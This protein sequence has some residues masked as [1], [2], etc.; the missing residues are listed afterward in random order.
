MK[1]SIK[2]LLG[3]T[4][5][6]ADG[7]IGKVADFYFDDR[8][9]T[10]RYMVVK[11]GGWFFEK[12]VLISSEAF[13]KSESESKTFSVN[14]TQEKIKNSPNIDTDKP[15][16][17]QQEGLMREYYSW[18]GYYGNGIQGYPG[19]GIWGYLAA[20][21]NSVEK[22]IRQ[23]KA[24]PHENDN[25]HLRSTQEVTGY[26]I[27]ATDGDMGDVEDFIVEDTTWKIDALVVETADWFLGKRVLISP[28]WIK[29]V[30]WQE[31]KVTL[32]HSKDEVKNS[33]EYDSSQ[34]INDFYEH[35]FTDYRVK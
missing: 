9:S 32:N 21:E 12:K 11:T 31:Q 18:P 29:N 15:V 33:P 34:P 30:K 35:S 7:E 25:P 5:K 13:E 6:G 28:Q 2:S 27:H 26:N 22:E 19:F 24:T 4:I 3:Y 17:R 10:V 1:Q 16:S 20:E 8:T 23:T 14:L